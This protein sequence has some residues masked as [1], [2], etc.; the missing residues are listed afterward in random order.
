M[1]DADDFCIRVSDQMIWKE[2]K[3]PS[4]RSRARTRLANSRDHHANKEIS[5]ISFKDLVRSGFSFR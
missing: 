4:A 3:I 2:E 5:T 1:P